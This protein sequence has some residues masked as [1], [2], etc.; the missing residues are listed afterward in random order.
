MD[1]NVW[2][3]VCCSLC[4]LANTIHSGPRSC[5]STDSDVVVS[6]MDPEIAVHRAAATAPQ[7]AGLAITTIDWCHQVERAIIIFLY[8]ASSVT[9]Y[10]AYQQTQPE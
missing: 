9:F 6:K 7:Q 1:H 2:G 5:V 4:T 8:E 10:E 3:I